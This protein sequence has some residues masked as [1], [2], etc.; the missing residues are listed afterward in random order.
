MSDLTSLFASILPYA[1]GALFSPLILYTLLTTISH[2]NKPRLS[3]FAYLFGSIIIFLILVFIGL[4][5]GTTLFGINARPVQTGAVVEVVLGIILLIIAIKTVFV[6]EE[7][8]SGGLVSFINLQRNNNLSVFLKFFYFGLI[9]FMASFTTAILITIAGII[10]SLSS[11]GFTN[12]AIIVIILGLISLFI[13][14]IPFI[15][16]LISPDAAEDVLD[17]FRDWAPKYGD[18]LTGIVYFI[19]GLFFIIRGFFSF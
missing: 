12:S 4:Y 9:A 15:F 3:S 8:R 7:S 18:Y 17:P 13:V 19:L 6:G 16:Y 1:I 14:E 11:P 2:R 5:I 10:I